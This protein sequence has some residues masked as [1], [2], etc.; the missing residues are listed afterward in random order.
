MMKTNCLLI[1]AVSLS[2]VAFPCAAPC[3]AQPPGPFLPDPARMLERLFGPDAP[4]D[5]QA[6][7]EVK[8]SSREQAELGRAAVQAYFDGL[9]AAQVRVLSRGRDP[10]YLR[11]LAA[12][13]QPLMT[14]AR[15]CPPLKL[16]LIDAAWFEARSFPDATLVFSRGM[17]DMAGSEA[18]VVSMI[19]HELSHLDH[20][21]HSIRLRRMKLAQSQLANARGGGFQQAFTAGMWMARIWTHPFRPEDESQ[22]DLDGARWAYQAGYDPREFSRLIA[23]AAEQEPNIPLPPFLRSHP[24]SPDR[25]RAL[26]EFYLELQKKAPKE[27]LYVGREN[28]R[29]RI[30]RAEQRF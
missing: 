11:K 14:N 1:A 16:Y 24:F 25:I 12:T 28:L 9:K 6:L 15:D 22:A 3:D 4:E 17:L 18:A 30:V 2:V 21:H 23:T 20:Q 19:G 7:A 26:A 5:E 27:D 13:V 29:R 8:I 10:D